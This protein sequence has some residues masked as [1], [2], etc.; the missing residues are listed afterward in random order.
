MGGSPASCRRHAFG[1]TGAVRAMPGLSTG[2]MHYFFVELACFNGDG[3]GGRL[4]TLCDEF[5]PPLATDPPRIDFTAG[6]VL[7]VL[8]VTIELL[9]FRVRK[10]NDYIILRKGKVNVGY[11]PHLFAFPVVDIGVFKKDFTHIFVL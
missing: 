3:A 7:V 10:L 11:A 9:V 2:R 4:T 8:V 1:V 5:Q 6:P